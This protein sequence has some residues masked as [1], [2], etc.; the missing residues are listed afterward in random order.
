MLFDFIAKHRD[1]LV[2]RAREKVRT[3]VAPAPTEIELT[4]G[5]PLFLDQFSSRLRLSAAQ[6][7]SEIGATASIHGAELLAA[8]FTIGQVVHGYGDICQSVMELAIE[9]HVSVTPT[10]F[11][12]LNLC[13]DIAIAEAV[14]QYAHG[15]EQQIVERGVEH[16]GFL[17]HE[18]R[19]LL[20]TATLA[21]EAVRSGSVGV[22]G[23]TGQLVATSLV[24]MS[25]LVT[26]SLAEV[27]LDGDRSREEHVVVARVL[28]EI[29]IA[30]TM[31]ANTRAVELAFEA[32][33]TEVIV[34]GD[35]QIIASILTNLV[36]NA[37]KFTRKHGRITVSTR[38]TEDR[39]AI[40]VA[41]QCGGLPPGDPE[42]LFKPY[43]QRSGDRTGAG[44]GLSI[45]RKGAVALGGTLKVRDLPGTGCVFTVTL[46]RSAAT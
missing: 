35:A 9:M 40:D 42:G 31:E 20:N 1:L 5:V 34:S 13:L 28:E 7:S 8:G 3:R 26:K 16:L 44:L 10:S 23:S 15:R 11:K 22:G 24:R 38:L 30:A 45:S 46:R 41:D 18:L 32:V 33:P 17:A 12:A 4:H 43:E 36:Q 39:V 14:T 27:R 19:N 25:E 6:S 29:Q 2:S 21:F 37:C